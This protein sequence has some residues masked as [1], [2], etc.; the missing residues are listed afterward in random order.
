MLRST[1]VNVPTVP[2][3]VPPSASN[4]PSAKPKRATSQFAGWMFTINNP[5]D[6]DPV[7]IE[8]SCDLKFI[9]Y[10]HEIAPGTGTP[11]IQGYAYF[12]R[13]LTLSAVK[14]LHDT[15]HWEPRRGT[16]DQAL[17]YVT[18][19]DSRDP[20]YPEPIIL[21]DAPKDAKRGVK[22]LHAAIVAGDSVTKLCEEHPSM[23][24]CFKNAL[25]VKNQLAP[26]R[27]RDIKV[28]ALTG[29]TGTGK[30]HLAQLLAPNAFRVPPACGKDN[31]WFD[32][33]GGETEVIIEEFYGGIKYSYLLQLLDKYPVALPVKGSHCRLL[34]TTI[35]LTSNAHPSTWYKFRDVGHP[36]SRIDYAPLERRFTSILNF[37]SVGHYTVEKGE[38]PLNLPNP[39]SPDMSC[40]EDDLLDDFHTPPSLPRTGVADKDRIHCLDCGA[41]YQ[42]DEESPEC[43]FCEDRRVRPAPRRKEKPAKKRKAFN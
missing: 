5:T 35:I 18:K 4:A 32:G 40:S 15:A 9:A 21:G 26:Q 17:A 19:E 6:A 25:L 34:A 20:A 24:N 38:D 3:R 29:P 43:P 8:E 23:L 42:C 31:M 11:H 30:S 10:Q 16:H 2:S 41:T 1:S 7:S 36:E 39:P 13:C 14:R 22:E 12:N 37:T 27:N 28:L 33:Y